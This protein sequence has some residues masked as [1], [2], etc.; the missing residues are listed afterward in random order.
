MKSSNSDNYGILA[1]LIMLGAMFYGLAAGLLAIEING[2]PQNESILKLAFIVSVLL[3]I[4]ATLMA[5]D[6]VGDIL[7]NKFDDRVIRIERELEDEAGIEEL[8]SEIEEVEIEE[9]EL[10]FVQ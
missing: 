10:V 7:A 8:I 3:G 9:E 4:G 1:V 5:V 2:E 6:T